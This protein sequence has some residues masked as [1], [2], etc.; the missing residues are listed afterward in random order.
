MTNCGRRYEK[1]FRWCRDLCCEEQDKVSLFS[2]HLLFSPR[3]KKLMQISVIF[4]ICENCSCLRK[5]FKLNCAI[6]FTL[7]NSIWTA[8]LDCAK[9][10]R[11]ISYFSCFVFYSAF[12]YFPQII[13]FYTFEFIIQHNSCFF[14]F[15]TNND[16]TFQK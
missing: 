14:Y 11:I 16:L 5:L 4:H 8:H 10:L 7:I 13:R 3:E 6:S 12:L 2:A 9:F 1:D 15:Q